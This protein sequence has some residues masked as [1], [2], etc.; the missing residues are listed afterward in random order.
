MVGKTVEGR[1]VRKHEAGGM[2][3]RIHGSGCGHIPIVRW[4]SKRV[5]YLG[6]PTHHQMQSGVFAGNKTAI[7]NP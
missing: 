5:K 6:V 2:R 1:K 4:E 3:N 7:R